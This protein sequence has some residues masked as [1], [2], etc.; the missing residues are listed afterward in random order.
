MTYSLGKYELGNIGEWTR[1]NCERW[2]STN[3]GDFQ[4]IED[5]RVDISSNGKDFV[6]EWADEESEFKFSDC[7][8]PGE[9]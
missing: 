2:L 6:S 8:Y 9:E 1:E 4:Y 3:S 5:F 7:M